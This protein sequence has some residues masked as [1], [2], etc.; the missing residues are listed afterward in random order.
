M[1]ESMLMEMGRNSLVLILTLTAPPLMAGLA[2]GLAVSIVQAVTQI[3]E[4]TLTFAPKLLAFF[5]VMA[6]LGPWMLQNMIAYT[7]SLINSLPGLVR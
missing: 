5:A 6:L 4:A 2:V 1:T 7:A 3:H